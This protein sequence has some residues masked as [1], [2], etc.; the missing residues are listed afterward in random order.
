MK[1]SLYVYK[2]IINF[3]N[4]D[5]AFKRHRNAI[6][7]VKSVQI[8]CKGGNWQ[9]QTALENDNGISA[10]VPLF[11]K[12]QKRRL[13]PIPLKPA[14]KKCSNNMTT[15]IKTIKNYEYENIFIFSNGII[16]GYACRSFGTARFEAGTEL[17]ESRG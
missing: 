9:T 6:L 8:L 7:R 11:L 1:K 2:I 3:K 10:T 12:P 13:Q 4:D 15:T 16:G 17:A 5:I 14:I